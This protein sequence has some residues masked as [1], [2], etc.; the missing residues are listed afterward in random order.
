MTDQNTRPSRPIG[1]EALKATAKALGLPR[2]ADLLVKAPGNDPF[3]NDR[4]SKVRD[5]EW[6][7]DLW[8][9][10]G[11]EGFHLRRVHYRIVSSREPILMPDGSVYEN[12]G[13]CWQKLVGGSVSARHLGL[14]DPRAFVDRRNGDVIVN[15]GERAGEPWANMMFDPPG[16]GLPDLYLP[17]L[18]PRPWVPLTRFDDVPGPAVFGYDYAAADEPSIVEVWIEKSTMDDVFVPLCRDLHVNLVRAKGTQSVTSAVQLLVRLEEYDRPGHVVYIAD[19]DRAGQSMA[20]S[21]ARDLEFYRERDFPNVD[22]TLQQIALT[23]RIE[24]H[25]L[26]HKPENMDVEL[27]ALEALVPGELARLVR[28]EVAA[29]RDPELLSRLAAT[30]ALARQ[31]VCDQ[32]AEETADVRNHLRVLARHAEGRLGPLREELEALGAEMRAALEPL[33]ERGEELRRRYDEALVPHREYVAKLER[34]I[35]GRAEHFDPELPERP[36]PAEPPDVDE[37]DVLFDSRRDWLEQ[38]A[39]YKRNG[40]EPNEEDAS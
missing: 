24:R 23:S 38:L 36:E 10:F 17:S 12:A 20:P 34:R 3:A 39:R 31:R 19:H 16:W 27:D 40:T 22:V 13:D 5:A 8:A 26:P 35:A 4:P 7:T 28:T 32:W 1:I 33:V 14:V 6:F 11:G 21:V 18:S 30:H 29:Y 15:A 25:D 2:Y 9:R 37:R